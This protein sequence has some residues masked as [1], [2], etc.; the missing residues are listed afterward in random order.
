[1]KQVS[2]ACTRGGKKI[3]FQRQQKIFGFSIDFLYAHAAQ[4]NTFVVLFSGGNKDDSMALM[5][6]FFWVEKKDGVWRVKEVVMWDV[7]GWV[8]VMVIMKILKF[9]FYF[10]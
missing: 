4:I 2:K 5:F 9:L 10:V 3:I 6:A 7:K 8:R 1:V